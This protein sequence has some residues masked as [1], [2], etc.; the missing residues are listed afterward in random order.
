MLLPKAL[1][2][3]LEFR[4]LR[5][6]RSGRSG[7]HLSLFECSAASPT[8]ALTLLNSLRQALEVLCYNEVFERSARLRVGPACHLER[9][10]NSDT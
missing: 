5:L 1:C 9:R 4:V 6:H 7:R 8:M 3:P 2:R 10:D